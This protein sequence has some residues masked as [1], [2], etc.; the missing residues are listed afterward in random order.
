MSKAGKYKTTKI[1][2]L[3]NEAGQIQAIELSNGGESDHKAVNRILPHVPQKVYVTADRGYDSQKLRRKI[4]QQYAN[5]VI[6][7]RQ[8]GNQKR[9]RTPKPFIYKLRW[10]IEVAFG[11][12]DQFKRLLVRYERNPFTYKQF[13][14]LGLAFLEVQKLTG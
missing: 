13:W 5:P 14:Y 2:A 3:C 4:R 10:L 6:P 9:R 8:Q 1:T 7:R 12:T 11:R